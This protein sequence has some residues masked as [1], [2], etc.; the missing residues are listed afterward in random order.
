MKKYDFNADVRFVGQQV[1]SR[2]PPPAL[3]HGDDIHVLL[4]IHHQS[5]NFNSQFPL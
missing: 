1:F 5:P 2:D 4:Y 3:R